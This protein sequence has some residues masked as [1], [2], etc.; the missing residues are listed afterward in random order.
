MHPIS[1]GPIETVAID[2][3]PGM[4]SIDITVSA[5]EA[6]RSASGEFVIVGAGLPVFPGRATTIKATGELLLTGYVRD[7]ET[8]YSDRDRTLACSFVSRTVDL[9]ETSIDHPSGEILNKDISAIARELD[10]AGVGIETD[11]SSFP[12]ERRHKIIEGESVFS[13]IARRSRGRG[14]LIHD[15][16]R[17]RMKLST[18]PGGVHAGTLRR[19]RNI[20]PGASASFTEAGR[21]SE[22][23]VRGQQSEGTEKQQLRPETKVTDSGVK[24][25]RVLILP[26]EGEATV[27]RMRTRAIWQAKRSA[28]NSV[29]ASIPVTGW[30]DG[31]GRLWQANWLV[32]VDDDWLGIRGLMIIK[33]VVFSQRG[34]DKTFA[35]LSLA[36]PRSLGGE[37]PRGKTSE[38]YAAP[39][40]I[41]AEYE[42]E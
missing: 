5:E 33:S 20:L 14:V 34:E 36:D 22:V 11:G 27:D 6:A 35:T 32:E 16:E 8:G 7:V 12:V 24:R 18:R 15:T 3:L 39:G 38:G 2:G 21:Y 23:K 17:G 4:K 26:H 10:S 19:G 25:N 40:A 28:G 37:N 9:I 13:S 30:R 29:T 42:D 1:K 31:N 41:E